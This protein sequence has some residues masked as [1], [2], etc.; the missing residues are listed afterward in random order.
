MPVLP[1]FGVC[2]ARIWRFPWLGNKL[3]TPML[4]IAGLFREHFWSRFYIL[5]CFLPFIGCGTCLQTFGFWSS[6]QHPEAN[7]A[8]SNDG[9]AAQGQ[10]LKCMASIPG[11]PD[12]FAPAL[13]SAVAKNLWRIA[14]IS[15][16]PKWK[17]P[18]LKWRLIVNRHFTP[19]CGL[20]S[21]VSRALDV[22]LDSFLVH[23]WSGYLS[24][25]DIVT[26]VRDFNT[27]YQMDYGCGV[28][29]D[30][31]DCFRHL[32][33]D[34]FGTM[35]DALSEFWSSKG[36]S[37][38]AYPTSG[39]PVVASF[40]NVMTLDGLAFVLILFAWCWLLLLARIMSA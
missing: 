40:V 12:H 38:W 5:G 8:W 19:C 10:V 13:H 7:F 37:W 34:Q 33:V 18:G 1:S 9:I 16:L 6:H 27:Q 11:L 17:C 2:W 39:W 35:W 3:A 29:A 15:L 21:L 23:L 30:M 28:A 26:L 22:L 24:M 14:S 4:E 36:V 32:P 25:G 31:T 20:H